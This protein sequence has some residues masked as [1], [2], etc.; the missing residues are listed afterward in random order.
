MEYIIYG[1]KMKCIKTE[2][3][4]IG[5]YQNNNTEDRITTKL[6]NRVTNTTGK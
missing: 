6:I 1:I 4:K 3:G 5:K 2:I